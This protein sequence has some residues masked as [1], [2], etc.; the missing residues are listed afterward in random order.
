MY[1]VTID[2]RHS[3][4]SS[5]RVPDL[6]QALSTVP[7][8]LGFE[9]TVGD[10]VQA[11]LADPAAVVEAVLRAVRAKDWS[12]GV[13]LG[14]VQLPLPASSREASGTAFIAA[15]EAVEQ[16]KRKGSK[17]PLA[18]CTSESGAGAKA[19]VEGLAATADAE[20]VLVLIGQLVATRSATQWVVLDRLRDEPDLPLTGIAKH[21]GI[22][23]QAV[24]GL[25]QRSHWQEEQAAL[26]AAAAL[27]ERAGRLAGGDEALG[28]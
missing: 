4:Q 15:R 24:G 7:T 16:A 22:S 21:V 6:L 28:W 10:E 3:R 19:R 17:L 20:A 26:P 12:I 25:L 5:D 27:L 11:L 23:H 8:V 18:L 9:R 14:S 1:V 2:Q 13:G